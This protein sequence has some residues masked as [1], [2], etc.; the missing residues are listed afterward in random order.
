MDLGCENGDLLNELKKKS[1]KK[2]VGVEIDEF[3]VSEA[4]DQGLEVI[5][6]DINTGLKRFTENQFDVVV[7]SQ[8]LQSIN[9]LEKTNKEILTITKKPLNHIVRYWQKEF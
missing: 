4:I 8:T 3:K 5:N 9:Y 2:L 6:C 7:L 1:C